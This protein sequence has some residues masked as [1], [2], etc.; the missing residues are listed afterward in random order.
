M[1][2][3]ILWSIFGIIAFAL[4]WLTSFVALWDRDVKAELVPAAA[5]IPLDWESQIRRLSSSMP[6]LS[7]FGVDTI[8][9]GNAAEGVFSIRPGE[10]LARLASLYDSI[11]VAGSTL[12]VDSAAGAALAFN[13]AVNGLVLSS[14]MNSFNST[15]HLKTLSGGSDAL[16]I[17]MPDGNPLHNA[18][19]ALL[20]RAELR[21]RAEEHVRA[22]DDV[23]AVLRLG[24]LMYRQSAVLS[25]NILGGLIL[26]EGADQLIRYAV[27]AQDTVAF[28]TAQALRGWVAAIPRHDLLIQAMGTDLEQAL[29]IVRNTDV[30]PAWRGLAIEQMLFMQ[31]RPKNIPLGIPAS[32]RARVSNLRTISD[33]RVAWQA[34]VAENSIDWFN[35]IGVADR[36]GFLRGALGR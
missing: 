28:E 2:K 11:G 13:P 21:S 26:G 8:V 23:A 20:V 33:P 36:V 6:D 35:G 32:V 34:E 10:Q 31:Y 12:Q 9:D 18:V 27:A 22:R 29:Q 14:R 25:E 16:W 4:V 19:R 5:A 7:A 15:E 30:I 3:K 24:D 1:L 17:V